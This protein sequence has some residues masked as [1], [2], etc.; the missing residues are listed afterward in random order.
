MANILKTFAL[1]LIV[2][3]LVF[4]CGCEEKKKK[5]RENA[6]NQISNV[7]T[8]ISKAELRK[9]INRKY[10]DADAHYELGK[11]YQADGLWEK[12][13][14]E[15]HIATSFDPAHWRA[16][17]AKVKMLLQKGDKPRSELTAEQAMNRAGVSAKSSLLL[18]KA[19]QREL[20]DEKAVA[21]YH[22]ALTLAPSSSALHR[23]IGYYY[24]S[25]NEKIRAEEYLRRSF[26][27]NPY[28]PEVAG[29][30]GRMGVIVQIP[31]KRQK[32]T[33]GLDKLLDRRD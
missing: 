11:I 22:Q 8:E 18:G 9:R 32:R 4:A 26:Q 31:R 17:A 10:T 20:L 23:Q 16:E 1:V 29:E 27:L 7:D 15:Y 2:S 6:L 12:A 28:Q 14:S 3:V 5:K 30:L 19:F 24:L 13:E 21:C 25:K 33:R